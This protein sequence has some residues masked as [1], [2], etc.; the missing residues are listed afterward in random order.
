V[1]TVL[2]WTTAVLNVETWLQPTL[3]F[4]LRARLGSS[5]EARAF[6]LHAVISGECVDVVR[7]VF[8]PNFGR[9]REGAGWINLI[10][11]LEPRRGADEFESRS[12]RV[13]RI[14]AA[15][16]AWN[17]F[18]AGKKTRAEALDAIAAA[19]KSAK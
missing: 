9:P 8:D 18:L 1:K 16:D 6:G 7:R 13:K 2:H 11:G 15:I 3:L 14:S 5:D 17:E 10:D 19:T 12:E 4:D